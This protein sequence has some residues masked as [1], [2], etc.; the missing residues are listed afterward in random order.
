MLLVSALVNQPDL[1]LRVALRAQMESSG[2]KRILDK[3]AVLEHPQLRRYTKLFYEDAVNDESEL[4]DNMKEDVV[5]NFSDPRGTFDAILANTDGRARDFLASGLKQLLLIPHDQ[6]T[7][8]RYFQLIEKLISAV[9]TDRKGLDGDFSALLGSSVSSIISRFGDEDRLDIA[10]EELAEAKS[11]IARLRR[12]RE[13]LEEEISQKDQG[14]V[15]ELKARIGELESHLE[16]SRAAGESLKS[17]LSSTHKSYQDKM[18]AL[19]LQVRELFNM[20]KEAK[21][22]ESVRDDGGVLDRR[23]LM[24]LMEK[25]IQRTKAIQRLE[26]LN[27]ASASDQNRDSSENGLVPSPRKSRFEDAPDESVRRHIED[28]ISGGTNIFVCP[29]S[30]SFYRPVLFF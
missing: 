10:E 6:E 13:A 2:L 8:T 9:V 27:P 11:T 16:T 22:L 12:Q 23:E 28:S 4:A 14:V 21:T 3:Y 20:L 7:R 17:E 15:G 26:G 29:L 30:L 18:A 5:M 24:N 25:K 1:A 19:E